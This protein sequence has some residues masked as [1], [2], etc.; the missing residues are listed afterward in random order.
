MFIGKYSSVMNRISWKTI[1]VLL[2]Q[3]KKDW[4]VRQEKS[5]FQRMKENKIVSIFF[6]G[7]FQIDHQDRLGVSNQE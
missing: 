4:C 2:T 6:S 5:K 3:I 7:E 1:S